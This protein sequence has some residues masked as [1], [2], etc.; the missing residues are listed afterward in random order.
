MPPTT[1]APPTTTTAAVQPYGTIKIASGQQS[2][3]T[4]ES[5]DPNFWETFWGWAIYDPLVTFDPQGNIKGVVADSWTLS[6]DGKTY[7][8]K[9]HQGIKFSNGDPLTAADVKFSVDRFAMH[10]SAN[11]TSTNPWSPYLNKNYASTSAPDDYTF[12]YNMQTPE[13]TLLVPFTYVRI[14]PQK[15]FNSVGGTNGFRAAPVGSGPYKFVSL[16]HS[17]SCTLEANTNY[18]GNPKPQY[19][20]VIDYLVPEEST[21]VAMLKSGDADIAEGLGAGQAYR[22]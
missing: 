19:K 10:D 8:F 7:T 21:R 3:F 11:T 16:V 9:I 12:I 4:Y 1:S 5:F 6:P 13:P 22:A 17:V 15:Y 2:G 18:W 20:T 14:L